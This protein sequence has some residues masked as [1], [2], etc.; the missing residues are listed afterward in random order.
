MALAGLRECPNRPEP[1]EVLDPDLLV[2]VTEDV[3]DKRE[4]RETCEV[5]STHIERTALVAHPSAPLTV[6]SRQLLVKRVVID[7]WPTATVAEQLGISRATAD[8][9]VRRYRAGP[10]RSRIN[11]ADPQAAR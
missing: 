2:V 5:L 3:V 10:A 1:P 6:F 11:D 8:K 7:G 9:W 4:P